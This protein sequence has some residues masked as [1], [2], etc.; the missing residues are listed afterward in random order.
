M[1]K[2][3][4]TMHTMSPNRFVKRSWFGQQMLCNKTWQSVL[5]FSVSVANAI[6]C[7]CFGDSWRLVTDKVADLQKYLA[8]R[9]MRQL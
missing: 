6:V 7:Y 4:C 9:A 1:N 5:T 3:R 8:K 2:K